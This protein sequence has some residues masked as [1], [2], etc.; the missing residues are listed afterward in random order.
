MCSVRHSY[1]GGNPVLSPELSSSV[2]VHPVGDAGDKHAVCS[3]R[4]DRRQS[5]SAD[6]EVGSRNGL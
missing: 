1:A 3:L 2:R 6:V 5:S 4:E